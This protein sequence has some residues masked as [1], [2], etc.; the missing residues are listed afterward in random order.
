[1]WHPKSGQYNRK[2][3]YTITLAESIVLCFL[4]YIRIAFP[5]STGISNTGNFKHNCIKD[6]RGISRY[7][8]ICLP[9]DMHLYKWIP[10]Y[11]MRI[12]V[13][14][15]QNISRH[16][17]HRICTEWCS[18]V[19]DNAQ[20]LHAFVFFLVSGGCGGVGWGHASLVNFCI[21]ERSYSDCYWDYFWNAVGLEL[22]VVLTHEFGIHACST[23]LHQY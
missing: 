23:G 7:T 5:G 21:L 18:Q 9:Q 13:D 6:Q 10:F 12:Q 14:H 19:T 11:R 3:R 1:M 2:R 22:G 16:T 15:S 20:A 4:C 8:R 17:C